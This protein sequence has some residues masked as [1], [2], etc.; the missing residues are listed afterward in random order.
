[1][2]HLNAVEQECQTILVILNEM[3]SPGKG[4]LSHFNHMELHG[5]VR[6]VVRKLQNKEFG[7]VLGLHASKCQ[8]KE[9]AYGRPAPDTRRSN[10]R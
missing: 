3:M 9:D 10:L 2:T 7:C 4:S 5:Q 1:M 6:D 8:C